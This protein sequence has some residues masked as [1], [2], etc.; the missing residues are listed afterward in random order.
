MKIFQKQHGE[1]TLQGQKHK[2]KLEKKGGAMSND[3][4]YEKSSIMDC[5]PI[6]LP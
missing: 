1:V 2:S 4:F 3:T 5:W 6:M